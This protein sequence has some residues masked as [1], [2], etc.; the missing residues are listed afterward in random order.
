MIESVDGCGRGWIIAKSDWWPS[1]ESAVFRVVTTFGD[2]CNETETCAVT[3]V[4]IPIGLPSGNDLRLC[5]SLA[6]E[7]LSRVGATACS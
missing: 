7:A 5:G 4:D 6:H 1:K 3:V 2:V